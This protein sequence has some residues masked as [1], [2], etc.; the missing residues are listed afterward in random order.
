MQPSER[1]ICAL[2]IAGLATWLAL[3][4]AAAASDTET[5][6]VREQL[7]QTYGLELVSYPFAAKEGACV[8]DSVRLAGP[9]GP[10]AAQ[11]ADIEYWPG[12]KEYVKAARLCFIVPSLKPLSSVEYTLSFGKERAKN[13]VTT[14]LQVKRANDYVEITTGKVGVRLRLGRSAFP[15]P[16]PAQDAPGPLAGMRLLDGNWAGGSVLTG[17]GKSAA[18]TA[19][20]TESGP[21]LARVRVVYTF[22]D[23]N[24]ATLTATVVAGD[25]AVRWDMA[26]TEDRPGLGIEF[27]LP[28]VPGAK[29]AVTLQGYGQWSRGDRTAALT[30]GD[31]PFTWLCPNTSI[32][33]IFPDCSWAL[34]LAGADGRELRIT[35]R[36]PALWA[37]AVAPLTYGGFKTWNLE[38]IPLSWENW[39]RKRLPVTYAADGTVT[40]K[41][42]LAKGARSWTVSSGVPLVG[43]RLDRIK[44]M[45]LDWPGN[46]VQSH[47]LLFV[48]QA[49][50]TD[51]WK[52]AA[53]DAELLKTISR[54]E[55]A[56]GILHLLMKP[57]DKRTKAEIDAAL[58]PVR[59]FLALLGNFDVMR[60]AIRAAAMY[61]A[62]INSGLLSPEE[63]TL[64]RAQMAYLGYQ[65]ADPQTWDMERGYHS[66][67][68]NM[69]VSYTLSLGVIAA[70][71][72]DHPM[73]KTWA[74]RATQWEDKWLTDE[75]GPNGEWLP[76]GS[77]YGVV[78]LE[79]LVTYAIAAQRA[80]F[81]DFTNDPRLKKL[82][83]Y[84]AKTQTPR[85]PQRGNLRATGAW[86]RGTSGD[87]HAVFGV[88]ARM[89][90]KTD[91]A[92]SQIMQWTWAEL[93]FPVFMG[94]GRLGGFDP[95]YQDRRLPSQAPVWSTEL[96]PNLG[97][98]FRSAFNTPNESYLIL[99]SH[100]DYLRNLDVWTP[101]I[102]GFSQ[103]FG[104]GRPVS[105]CF[106]LDTGYAVRHELL[107][108]GVR[109]ARNWG[110]PGD[111]KTPFGYLVKTDPQA[112]ALQPR[113][114]YIRSRFT[115]TKAD[116]RD[117]FPT[118]VPPAFP[119]V[120][121]AKE[122][123]LDWTRQ[124]LFLKDADPAGPAYVILR[125]TTSG[126]QPT[127]W[128]FWTLSEKIG[129]PE[130]TKDLA[131]FLA[132]KPG[133]KLLPARELPAGNRYTAIGQF[134]MDIEFFIA[135]PAGTPR[136][137]LR[138]GGP[139][140]SRVPEYE[141]LLH[142][143]QPGDSAYYLAV[144]PRPRQE[145]SPEFT[146]LA[147]G[148]MIKVA[149]AFGADYA[150]LATDATTATAEDVRMAGTAAAVQ[151]R[152]AGTTLTLGA[153]GQVQW[154]TFG[155]QARQ[156]ATLLATQDIL[157]LSLTTDSTGGT[158]AIIAPA[159][160][161]LKEPVNGV[162][163]E[164]SVEGYTLTLAAGITRVT[165]VKGR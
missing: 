108:D 149:G 21:V 98:F 55:D 91:P 50:L 115:Y 11:L 95:Y 107:R 8:A 73:A 119:R 46:P 42:A 4:S 157:N 51:V 106:N 53:E 163:F 48:D 129:V 39:K 148:K 24:A 18:W 94:D 33:N 144:F 12:K 150:L 76:E 96:F 159:G 6:T 15:T 128:Q 69:S 147:D 64:F 65:L 92:F 117:W 114:D 35:A 29:Q 99:L 16:V 153:A 84:H 74:Q 145:Q 62:A 75:V 130:Q 26:V 146:A 89:T 30:P 102:G 124:V 116:D 137:T 37:D 22:A 70:A 54:N 134:D 57:A 131:A 2:G 9:E 1:P 135:S 140:N 87:K 66:G 67:N 45:V 81:H 72:R 19:K 80:G 142:L 101:G 31:Q 132:D 158:L 93:G 100:T 118:L 156:P 77:H 138:Y 34:K 23:R 47:P 32:A 10:V 123:K 52:R 88:A 25:N 14:D 20:L 103:W 125:D 63:R 164:A 44:D 83:L 7:N 110:E 38:M 86:G 71:L 36:Y 90:A 82:L 56:A 141:D 112:V 162:T 3:A 105:T 104:R 122:P 165:L 120:V 152:P 5:I 139:D 111:P 59:D 78:S 136:H 143:Q 43:E 127:A 109:L 68:P 28:P 85:D 121:P 79:P 49:E 133:T 61:D 151:V 58:K 126:G 161:S 160:W 97:V 154:K 13:A 41:A 155:L 27:R 17:E 60:S 40:L 113:A